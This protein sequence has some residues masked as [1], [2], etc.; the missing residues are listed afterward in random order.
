M[1]INSQDT[2]YSNALVK[3]QR[4]RDAFEG[5]DAV[6]SRGASYLPKLEAHTAN[7]Y[8]AYKERALFLPVTERTMGMMTGLAFKTAPDIEVPT[9][10][11]EEVRRHLGDVTLAGEDF[12]EFAAHALRECLLVARMGVL[13]EWSVAL[14]RPYWIAFNAEEIIARRFGLL[15]SGAIGLTRVVIQRCVNEADPDD[16]YKDAEV[17]EI[18]ELWLDTSGGRPVYRQQKWRVQ[19]DGVDQK[20]KKFG[21]EVVPVRNGAP[22]DRIPFV[23]VQALGRGEKVCKAPMQDL[24]DVNL[25]HYRTS[26]DWE[27]GAHWT[28]LPTPW[29]TGMATNEVLT[30]GGN[31]AWV[32]QSQHA[33]V[34]LLEYSGQG[35]GALEKLAER[36]EHLMATL[37]ARMLADGKRAAETAESM[38][39]RASETTASLGDV[40]ENVGKALTVVLWLHLWWLY[41]DAEPNDDDVSV[42]INRDFVDVKLEAPML[43]A[44][45]GAV[46]AGQMSFE[47][48]Y[49]N[50]SKGGVAEPGRIAEEEQEL[51]AAQAE[52]REGSDDVEG[53]SGD[54]GAVEDEE[55]ETRGDESA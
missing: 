44:L 11:E 20:Y 34:G 16:P 42:E 47:T 19:G 24:V 49:W 30:V 40:V 22:L 38:R 53:G 37:G 14:R 6:K 25:S 5:S 3:W 26:A 33:R 10:R 2:D 50:L 35:L 1:P 43:T 39:L 48:F 4:C 8:A 32:I 51:I 15:P 31:R 36:K 9:R 27:H 54:P 18:L 13:V 17:D 52:S 46:Q 55:P 41:A 28:A 45:V 21:P 23:F 12:D 7:D 29:V